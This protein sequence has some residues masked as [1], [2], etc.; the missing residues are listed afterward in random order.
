MGDAAPTIGFRGFYGNFRHSL[1][2]KGRI[3]VP[4]KFRGG[5]GELFMLAKGN[6]DCLVGYALDEWEAIAERLGRIP[7]TDREGREFA[8]H[9]FGSAQDCEV[10][11]QGRV[12]INEDLR[13][14][15]NLSKDVCFVGVRRYFEIWDSDRYRSA[16]GKYDGH[17]D[18]LAEKMQKYLYG[19]A[20]GA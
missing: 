16:S 15:A 6:D 11:K 17:A 5:L 8:R 3:A 7:V 10:D 9:V 14:Y 18:V 4:V 20:A 19:E 1:D 2:T 12:N 13:A